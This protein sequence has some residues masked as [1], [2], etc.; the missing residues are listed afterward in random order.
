METLLHPYLQ[1]SHIPRLEV[2]V[3]IHIIIVV[4]VSLYVLHITNT[5]RRIKP[6]HV[7]LHEMYNPFELHRASKV[8]SKIGVSPI[9]FVAP[10]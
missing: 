8:G 7:V 9:I 2:G 10:K 5:C 3:S 4:V 6:K 1:S